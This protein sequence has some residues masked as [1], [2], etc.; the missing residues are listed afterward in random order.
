MCGHKIA[1]I[2]TE[3][4]GFVDKREAKT[5][6]WGKPKCFGYNHSVTSITDNMYRL[7]LTYMYDLID[8]PIQWQPTGFVHLPV[9]SLIFSCSQSRKDVPRGDFHAISWKGDVEFY[10][11]L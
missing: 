2:T 7:S 1:V 10:D 6:H 11:N 5:N 8:L 9:I 4:D 3:W